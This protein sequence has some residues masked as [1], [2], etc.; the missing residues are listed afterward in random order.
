MNRSPYPKDQV[1]LYEKFHNLLGIGDAIASLPVLRYIAR[2]DKPWVRYLFYSFYPELVELFVPEIDV[3]HADEM[4]NSQFFDQQAKIW[5]GGRFFIPEVTTLRMSLTENMYLTVLDRLP[6]EIEH[7]EYPRFQTS[8]AQSVSCSKFDLVEGQYIIIPVGHIADSRAMPRECVA[9][10]A[11]WAKERGF[12]PVFTGAVYKT[13]DGVDS[14]VTLPDYVL[15]MGVNLIGKTSLLDMLVLLDQSRAV[16]GMDSGTIHLAG[17]TDA[18]IVVCYTTVR[19]EHRLPVRRGMLGH[20]CFVVKPK[21]ELS[22]RYCQ[23]TLYEVPGNN[24][25]KCYFKDYACMPSAEDFIEQLER[26]VYDLH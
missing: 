15:E 19:P 20:D 21:K 9:G 3:V 8:A 7:Y 11:A 23:D 25:K 26:A 10:V 12:T 16:V 5:K 6:K 17:C 13:G 22:C 14:R 2:E 1:V 4:V 24:F 18:P